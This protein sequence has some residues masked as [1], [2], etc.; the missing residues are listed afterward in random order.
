MSE[1]ENQPT[2]PS[3]QTSSVP[4]KKETVRITLKASDAPPARPSSTVPMRPPVRPPVPVTSPVPGGAPRPLQAP[5]TVP[6]RPAVGPAAITAAP[7]IPLRSS[8]A[9]PGTIA[10]PTVRIS[11]VGLPTLPKATVP[12]QK[13]AQPL[14]P[15]P[16]VEPHAAAAEEEE[17]A[18]QGQLL[19]N[20][21]SGVGLVA[22][23]VVFTLQFMAASKWINAEDNPKAG[24]WSQLSPF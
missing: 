17:E 18:T 9:L 19:L 22:A 15:G 6:L 10:A 14:E 4:L 23:L 12:L 11:P 8:V 20:V 21:L 16:S 5:P 3:Q 1:N 2:A 13:T 24:Q 7:T